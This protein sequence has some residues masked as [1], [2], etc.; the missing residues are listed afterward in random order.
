[1]L[2]HARATHPFQLFAGNDRI[3]RQALRA[4]AAGI[5][6]GVASAVPE[7]LVAIDA[8]A[9]SSGDTRADALNARLQEFIDRIEPFP[10]P[11]GIREA[12]GARGLKPGPHATPLGETAVKRLFDF[13]QWF[14]TWLPDVL[15][16]CR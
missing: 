10:A 16:E 11:V 2:A 8:A 15:E 5:I 1:M 3:Y 12:A 9:I 13:R 14:T 6:S 4:G 7:L